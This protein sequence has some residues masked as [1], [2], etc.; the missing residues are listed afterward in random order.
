MV[1]QTKCQFTD[2]LLG[3]AQS[4]FSVCSSVY[5]KVFLSQR[6]HCDSLIAKIRQMS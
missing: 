1:F 6:N 4:L 5:T 3:L 2:T